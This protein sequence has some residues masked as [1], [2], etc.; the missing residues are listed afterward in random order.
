MEALNNREEH[1]VMLKR[2]DK[3]EYVVEKTYKLL[4]AHVRTQIRFDQELVSS[5]NRLDRH[6]IR[7]SKLEKKV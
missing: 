2:L 5:R 1:T 6:E 7:I 3:I 4:D